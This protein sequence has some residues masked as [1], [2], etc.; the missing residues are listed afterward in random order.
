MVITAESLLS[1]LPVILAN[2]DDMKSLAEAAAQRL[3]SRLEE[4]EK[5]RIYPN[6]KNADGELLDIL[7][8]DFKVD[9]WNTGYTLQEKR[10][11]FEAS[12][13]THRH[14]GT[15]GSV[16]AALS[17]IY[18]GGKVEE[19]YEYDGLPYHFAVSIWLKGTVFG[20]NEQET[21]VNKINYFKNVRSVMDWINFVFPELEQKMKI[22]THIGAGIVVTTMPRSGV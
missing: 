11:V 5:A 6:I 17:S 18:G 10:D 14:M 9:W 4:I 8:K 2:D 22:G 13:Y 12:F 20:P 3:S 21:I 7:A 16:E 15:P 1:V 19:W